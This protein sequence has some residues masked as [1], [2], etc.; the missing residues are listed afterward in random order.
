MNCST[1]EEQLNNNVLYIMDSKGNFQ[2]ASCGDLLNHIKDCGCCS[3]LYN[4]EDRYYYFWTILF[5]FFIF[6]I[7][8]L[9][10]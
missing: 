6:V 10:K 5:I 4:I 8:W 3:K 1:L 2:P 9:F 7:V